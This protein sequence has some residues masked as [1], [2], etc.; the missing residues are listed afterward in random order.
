MNTLVF[1][2]ANAT[3]NYVQA[4]E[5]G[6]PTTWM[7]AKYDTTWNTGTTTGNGTQSNLSG[8]KVWERY[9]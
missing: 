8:L 2:N 5:I 3:L 9:F 6:N 1:T 4:D 7:Y